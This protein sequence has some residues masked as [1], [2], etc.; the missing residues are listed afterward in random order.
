MAN[1]AICHSNMSGSNVADLRRMQPATHGLFK[2][3]LLRGAFVPLGMPRWDDVFSD[4][5]AD[6]IHAYL[7]ALQGEAHA[8]YAKAQREGRDP[9]AATAV[10]ALRAH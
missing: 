7:I 4:A 10:T 2:D 3:I 9:D 8:A 6:A 1:C 5:Q